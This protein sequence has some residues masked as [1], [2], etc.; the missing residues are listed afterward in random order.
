MAKEDKLSGVTIPRIIAR[1]LF[2][3]FNA[4]NFA[5]GACIAAVGEYKNLL[6]LCVI[7]ANILIGIVQDIRSKHIV[8]Q[9]SLL[10]AP[11]VSVQQ[12]G[13]IKCIS[14]DALMRGDHHPQS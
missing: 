6:Y 9:L 7:F 13:V 3:P 1:H 4:F 5:I 11:S 12:N 14:P 10:N 2:T 8:D